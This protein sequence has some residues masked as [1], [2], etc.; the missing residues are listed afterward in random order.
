MAEDVDKGMT[1]SSHK[2]L[3]APLSLMTTSPSAAEDVE[4]GFL[5]WP[6]FIILPSP[7]LTPTFFQPLLWAFSAL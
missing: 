2:R 1:C 5:L 4:V 6:G 7:S 3:S